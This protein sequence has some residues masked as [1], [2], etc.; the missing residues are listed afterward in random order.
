M[1]FHGLLNGHTGAVNAVRWTQDGNYC[2]SASEDRTVKLWNPHKLI[3][4]ASSRLVSTDEP[5]HDNFPHIKSYSGAHGYGINDIAIFHDNTRFVT[6]GKDKTILVWDVTS[7]AVVRRIQAHLHTTNAL[8]LNAESTILLSAS[9]DKTVR[10]WDLRSQS[11]QAIQILSDFRDSV[12]SVCM[13]DKSILAG[14]VDGVL[15]FYDVRMGL[16]HEDTVG[17][18]IVWT[19]PAQNGKSA[20]S[21]CLA[22]Q[23]PDGGLHLTALGGVSRHPSRDPSLTTT[24]TTA[25]GPGQWLQT[26]TGGLY[27]NFKTECCT[28]AEDRYVAAGAED[29]HVRLWDPNSGKLLYNTAHMQDSFRKVSHRSPV[30][31]VSAHPSLPLLLS[32]AH[33]GVVSCWAVHK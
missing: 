18:P 21:L 24:V 5:I 12:T 26:F 20:L 13:V 19:V 3:N 17:D 16:L 7:G 6:G 1:K 29:G 32:A 8:S 11:R 28:V 15:R 27:K 33:D 22:G 9:Y 25:S 14:C 4:E 30:A 2:L 23:L 10:L 31:S